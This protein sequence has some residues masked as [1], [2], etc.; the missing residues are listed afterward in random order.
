VTY[1]TDDRS[2][3]SSAPR[4]GY[5]FILPAVT[6]R[7]A[8]GVRDV[9]INGQ[10]YRAGVIQRGAA[11]VTTA[12]KEAA[13]EIPI[14]VKHALPQRYLQMGVPP[15]RI[16]VN[17]YCK[18]AGGDV[19]LVWIGRVLSMSIDGHVAKFLVPAR[20]TTALQRRI[21]T[22]STGRE[23]PHVLY[24]AGC[25]VNAAGFTVSRTV[26]FVD[27]TRIDLSS[28]PNATDNWAQHGALLHV[29]SGERVTIKTQFGAQLTVQLPI[30]G[31]QAGDAV[32]VTAGCVHE[33]QVCSTK[34]QNQ[35][36]Y[37]GLP[38]KPN[39]NPFIP[40]EHSLL[41]LMRDFF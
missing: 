35:G 5:E 3:E 38:H 34:F 31:M 16:D 8:S 37:G 13:L 4:E 25:N 19:Q 26:T 9:V 27:G 12:T 39:S 41:R 32:E 22:I 40:Y 21:P 18:Q 1:D 29:A 28:A 20:T 10:T 7:L 36:N 17:V 33:I 11:E 30:P 14:D 23:C 24:E 6:Y 15:R 2:I